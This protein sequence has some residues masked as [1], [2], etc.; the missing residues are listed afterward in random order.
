MVKRKAE[1]KTICRPRVQ[2][3]QV[4]LAAEGANGRRKTCRKSPDLDSLT[5][6]VLGHIQRCYTLSCIRAK[7]EL[8]YPALKGCGFSRTVKAAKRLSGL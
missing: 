5:A 8:P 7:L 4:F 3:G 2:L 6:P 1:W